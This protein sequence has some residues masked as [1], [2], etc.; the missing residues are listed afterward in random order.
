MNNQNH[1]QQ[2]LPT[3]LYV[4]ELKSPEEIVEALADRSNKERRRIGRRW[5]FCGSVA[6]DMFQVLRQEPVGTLHQRVT[7]FVSKTG[8]AYGVL[9]HQVRGHQHRLVLP[10]FDAEVQHAVQALTNESFGFL[11]SKD[12]QEESLLLLHSSITGDDMQGLPGLRREVD[13]AALAASIA[14]LPDVLMALG[15]TERIPSLE[16]EPTQSVSVSIV[17]PVHSM[18]RLDFTLAEAPR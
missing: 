12:G 15:N 14:E 2:T 3:R 6:P 9:T 16:V 4:G 13:D 1:Y 7:G 8:A 17:M 18:A 11:M 5:L 10:L